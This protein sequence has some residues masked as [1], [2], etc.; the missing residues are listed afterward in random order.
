MKLSEFHNIFLCFALSIFCIFLFPNATLA[1]KW[2]ER[3]R[4]QFG[5]ATCKK[6]AY[7][8][9][10][11]EIKFNF[12]GPN[13]NSVEDWGRWHGLEFY[14]RQGSTFFARFVNHLGNKTL[15]SLKIIGEGDYR[16]LLTRTDSGTIRTY[17]LLAGEGKPARTAPE[18]ENPNACA[19]EMLGESV[20]GTQLKIVR[21]ICSRMISCTV[22]VTHGGVYNVQPVI[23]SPMS[24]YGG[25]WD[26]LHSINNCKFLS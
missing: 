4:G 7:G 12:R 6:G 10:F 24:T 3:F 14:G 20:S 22:Q 16:S 17:Y 13:A 2:D 11:C 26:H 21:N 5:S 23:I 15:Y 1:Q 19:Q 25:G 8:R 9:E 18:S